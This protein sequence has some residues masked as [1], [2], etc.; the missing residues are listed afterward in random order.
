MSYYAVARGHNIGIYNYWNDCKEQ[1]IGYKGA[2]YKKFNNEKDAEDYILNI[3]SCTNDIFESIYSK[4]TDNEVDYF[5]Y[6][7]G[8]CLNNGKINNISGIGIY[9]EE[10][11]KKNVSKTLESKLNQT[12]N[13]AELYAIIEAY[14]IIKSDLENNMKICIYSD[15]EYSIKC[16]TSYGEKCSVAKWCKAIPNKELVIELYNIYKNNPNLMLKHIRAHT[17]KKDIHSIG[18]SNADKL[19]YDA[20]KNYKRDLNKNS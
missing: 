13:S 1:V 16:A 3:G 10:N 4:F 9:F 6:T 11:S 5:V 15:S 12:N 20:I 19:A 14:K 18:N 7:D 17:N 2:V 8:S